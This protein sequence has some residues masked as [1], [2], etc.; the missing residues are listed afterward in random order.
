MATPSARSDGLLSAVERHGTTLIFTSRPPGPEFG[1]PTMIPLFARVCVLLSAAL[2]I[3]SFAGCGSDAYQTVPVRGRVMC[4]GKPAWGGT[5]VFH[6]IDAPDKTGRPAGSPGRSAAGMVQEDGSFTLTIRAPAGGHDKVG[7]LVGPH[8]VSFL[9]PKSTP[10]EMSP[11]DRSL[12]PE[13][14]EEILA[15]LA[16]L[17]VFPELPCSATIN[18]SEVEVKPGQN[19]FEFVL[20]AAG[21]GESTARGSD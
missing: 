21:T 20:E 14:L 16:E 17:P 8:R 12:P 10:Y 7:A 6:A 13:E 4:E 18:P 2:L 9:L 3:A 19:E 5:V 1:E 11:E 15:A